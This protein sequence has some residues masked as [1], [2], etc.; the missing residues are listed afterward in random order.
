MNR[1]GASYA[2]MYPLGEAQSRQSHP[3]RMNLYMYRWNITIGVI[4]LA[5][6]A[7]TLHQ[8][9]VDNLGE[10]SGLSSAVEFVGH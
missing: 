10:L 6:T 2:S 4:L 9:S 5:N 8:L 7:W 3:L 1:L